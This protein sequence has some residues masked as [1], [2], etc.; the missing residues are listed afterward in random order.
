MRDFAYL[1]PFGIDEAVQLMSKHQPGARYIAGGTTLF[2]LMKLGVEAP[3]TVIDITRIEGLRDIDASA[4]GELRIG[5]LALMSDVA[6]DP[7]VLREFPALSESLWKAASQQLR[8][9]ATVGGNLLQRTRCAYFRGSPEFACNKRVPGSGCAA[10]GGQNR[11]HAVLGGSDACVA[12]YPG[13]MAVALAAFDAMVDTVSPRGARSLPVR[14]LHRAPGATPHLETV[15]ASDEL[16]VRIRVPRS[17]VG[18]ASSYH[19]VRDRESYAFALTSAAVAVHLQGQGHRVTDARIALGGVATRP[20]RALQAERSLLGKPL[21]R[22]AARQAAE[23]AFEGAVPLEHNG[24]KV[25]L[26]IETVTD[27]LMLAK[28]RS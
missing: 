21:T 10:L 4:R 8:N 24:F 7:V 25:A 11:G 6:E 20:W 15:L 2:D 9:M 18:R 23:L 12:V 27:A 28:E 17:G 14:E 13:D 5:A 26:G 22:A 16:I 3:S 19:K 1:R